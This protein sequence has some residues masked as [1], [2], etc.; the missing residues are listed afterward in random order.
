MTISPKYE[1]TALPWRE[2]A[3]G[4]LIAL[5]G[6]ATFEGVNLGGALYKVELGLDM[7]PAGIRPVSVKVTAAI[8][9]PPV[10]GTALR[11][12]R[13]ADLARTAIILGALR[14]RTTA[15]GKG[16]TRTD[17]LSPLTDKD[18]ELIRLRGP[19]R[20]S[21]EWAAYFYNLGQLAGLP[22]ARQVELSLGLPRST[23]A[24]WVKRARDMGLI[25]PTGGSTDGER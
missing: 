17:I 19:V 15:T 4:V 1:S 7:T 13:V 12:V 14:G 10:T 9:G 8:G 24:K 18:I 6:T 2:V 3:P 21:V 11:A 22:P 20:E 5:P 23:A 25:G 16:A